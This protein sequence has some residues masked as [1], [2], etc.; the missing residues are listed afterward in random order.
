MSRRTKDQIISE[1]VSTLKKTSIFSETN[2]FILKEIALQ[3]AEKKVDKGKLIFKKGSL[4]KSMYIIAKGMVRIHDG[5]HVYSKMEAGSVFGE[6]ALIDEETRS[7]SVTAEK[8]SVLYK[9]EQEDFYTV[10]SQKQEIAKGILKVLIK[11]I[12]NM[13]VLEEKLS[14][15]FLKVQTQK[16]VIES[17]HLGLSEKK[18][19]L[20]IQNYDL[21]ALN[22]E[23]N[24]QISI[25]VHGMKNPLTSSL[26]MTDLLMTESDNLT[27]TQKKYIEIVHSSSTRM[28]SLINEILNID[29]IESK[30]LR[31]KLERLNLRKV[32]KEVVDTLEYRILQKKLT[33]D[34]DLDLVDAKLNQIYIFQIIENLLCNAIKFTESAKSIQVKL[35]S[36]N[37]KA[38]IEI[39]DQGCGIKL[40][41]LPNIFN[42]YERQTNADN[43]TPLTGLGLAIVEKYVNAMNG[44]VSCHSVYGEGTKFIISFDEFMV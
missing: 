8:D 12:R 34:L 39:I 4:G 37:H 31:L 41:D 44:E 10:L 3:L 32:I 29:L 33:L 23:K 18:Q 28:N 36:K 15:N 2:D 26:C 40:E 11:R 20:E 1:R 25:L 38:I 7:A 21:L 27:D 5:G 13:N 16:K 43:K 35:Y 30:T 6:Y 19:L 17:Q 9:L 24:Q 22:E 14:K 42:I